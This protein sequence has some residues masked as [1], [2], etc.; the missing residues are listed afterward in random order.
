MTFSD[1]TR[2]TNRQA[3]NNNRIAKPTCGIVWSADEFAENIRK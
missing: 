1:F 2:N 3:A